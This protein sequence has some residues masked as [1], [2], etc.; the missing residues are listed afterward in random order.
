M[1]ARCS[2][3]GMLQHLFAL[4]V[5]DG[6]TGLGF[7]HLGVIRELHELLEAQTQ[8]RRVFNIRA[9]TLAQAFLALRVA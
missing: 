4:V 9:K 7:C 2:T 6:E 8:R 5:S 3:E 1:V